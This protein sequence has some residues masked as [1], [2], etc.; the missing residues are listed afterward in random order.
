MQWMKIATFLEA[1]LL[2]TITNTLQSKRSKFSNDTGLILKKIQ[3]HSGLLQ[4]GN[5]STELKISVEF[6]NG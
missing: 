5:S 4:K 1:H 3:S 6:S 2:N